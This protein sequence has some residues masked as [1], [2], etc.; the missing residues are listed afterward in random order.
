MRRAVQLTHHHTGVREEKQGPMS[1]ERVK[2]TLRHRPR[3]PRRAVSLL[4]Y[5]R[6]YPALS[7]DR[8]AFRHAFV[9]NFRHA[10]SLGRH[11]RPARRTAAPRTLLGAPPQPAPALEAWAGS[12]EAA[13]GRPRASSSALR[14][15]GSAGHRRRPSHGA[16]PRGPRT[17]RPRLARQQLSGTSWR[18]EQF[19]A[20]SWGTRA[21]RWLGALVQLTECAAAARAGSCDARVMTLGGDPRRRS[22]EAPRSRL[23]RE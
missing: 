6:R 8:L 21:H 11:T 4:Y 19:C 2:H 15:R 17:G 14:G 20:W 16:S 3:G 10:T 13:Q 12:I 9:R 7:N 5:T 1:E 18:R 22:P 23:C